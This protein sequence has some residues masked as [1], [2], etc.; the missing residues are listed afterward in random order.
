[1]GEMPKVYDSQT[2]HFPTCDVC[3]GNLGRRVCSIECHGKE[4][5]VCSGCYAF[6]RRLLNFVT[7]GLLEVQPRPEVECCGQSMLVL[8]ADGNK[9]KCMA[10]GKEVEKP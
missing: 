10:C 8:T 5:I 9:L 3:M 2:A 7:V 6:H 4:L 1:M